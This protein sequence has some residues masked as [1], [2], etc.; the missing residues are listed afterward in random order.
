MGETTSSEYAPSAAQSGSLGPGSTRRPQQKV[1]PVPGIPVSLYAPIELP[2]PLEL[3]G[4]NLRVHISTHLTFNP[5]TVC[6]AVLDTSLDAH[7]R[8][9]APG[10]HQLLRKLAYVAAGKHKPTQT[11][12]RL[13]ANQFASVVPMER[14]LRALD[15]ADVPLEPSSDWETVLKGAEKG[16][17][18]FLKDLCRVLGACDAHALYVRALMK[19]G[20]SEQA[21]AHV[22]ALFGRDL[23]AWS[24]LN[25]SLMPRLYLL[26][27][28]ALKALAWAECRGPHP[29]SGPDP[30]TSCLDPLLLPGRRP[31]GHWLAEVC[32][33]SGCRNLRQLETRL[34]PHAMHHGRTISHDL[35]RKWASCA[36]VVMPAAALP[37]VVAAVRG[38]NWVDTL[39]NRF[40]VARFLTFLCDLLRAGTMGERPTWEAVQAQVRSRYEQAY[41]LQVAHLPRTR[42]GVRTAA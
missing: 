6:R 23:E 8:R 12:K 27:E 36:K 30:D 41:R 32:A 2:H 3:F 34:P 38:K 33:A 19:S 40:Y 10:Q 22:D 16:Q 14:M 5:D 35:L 24:G 26:V 13:I 4:K 7:M 1:G 29:E 42:D 15:G 21:V 28:V 37:S 25:A 11:T 18:Q 31:M 39:P 9:A 20:Q 17:D